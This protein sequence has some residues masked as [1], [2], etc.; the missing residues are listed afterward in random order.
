MENRELIIPKDGALTFDE[1]KKKIT[2][3]KEYSSII[4]KASDLYDKTPILIK[5]IQNF[6]PTGIAGAIDQVL[7]DNKAKR[8]QENL[9]Q[10]LYEL[11]KAIIWLGKKQLQLDSSIE[12]HVPDL[13]SLYFEKSKESYDTQKIGYYKNIWLNGV[14]S[15]KE[16]LEEKA[17]VF[18]IV[19][20]LSVDEILVLSLLAG[21]QA[22]HDFQKREP[23][24]IKDI[25]D[26][27]HL[28]T[29]RSQQ[30]C[31]GLAG[32]GLL[33]DYGLGR[34]D[35]DEPF[36]FVITDYVKAYFQISYRTRRIIFL[37]AGQYHGFPISSHLPHK[38]QH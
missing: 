19:S 21:K 24:T 15:D 23:L 4:D 37:I 3:L 20:S 27:N 17:Y 26:Q 35:Y 11:Y 34:W 8:E 30:L 28:S 33:H 18:N 12:Q 5:A 1:F 7:S 2:E 10:A 25:A 9:T 6:D 22:R 31:I 36:K 14:L 16:T 32:K 38:A 29:Q 13:T